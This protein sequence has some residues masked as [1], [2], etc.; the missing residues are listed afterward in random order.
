MS[1]RRPSVSVILPVRDGAP[2][3]ERCLRALLAGEGEP[4]EVLVVDDGSTDGTPEIVARYPVRLLTLGASRGPAHARNR[5]AELAGGEILFFVDADVEVPPGALAAAA[6]YLADHPQV[7]A[8]IG[9]YD[10]EPADPGFLSQ[11]RNLLHH[12]V[13]QHGR[14]EAE[15]FWSGC[16]AIRRESLH[17]AGGFSESFRR[18][19][20]EDIELGGRLR[21]LGHPIRLLKGLQVKHLKRWRLGNLLRTDIL[22][23]AIPWTLLVLA[24][25]YRAGDLNLQRR[26]RLSAGLLFLGATCLAAALL[27]QPLLLLPALLAA[28]LFWLLNRDLFRFFREARGALFACKTLPLVVLYY[29]YS[30]AGF[31]AGALLYL[32]GRRAGAGGER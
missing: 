25:E 5:G 24:G 31:A 32:A 1:G 10:R 3:I 23:R 15:T 19:S 22:D 12:F 20:V 18:P 17:A 26:Y 7:A 14:E 4:P 30:S 27:A 29:L 21:R 28:L 8:V 6:G 13:H 16:G 11:Y 9:S 2:T